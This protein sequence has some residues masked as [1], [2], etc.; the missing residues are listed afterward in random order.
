MDIVKLSFGQILACCIF[1]SGTV[2]ALE[3]K[4][5]V[6]SGGD[7]EQLRYD[8]E[9]CKEDAEGMVYFS[10]RDAVF[11]V[12]YK[13]L[14]SIRG[15]SAESRSNLP[16]RRDQAEQ[17][18]CPGNPLWGKGFLI[19]YRYQ[20]TREDKAVEAK[21]VVSLHIIASSREGFGLQRVNESGFERIRKSYGDC[22]RSI[23]GLI[24]CRK[25]TT[26]KSLAGDMEISG[27][28]TS[29]KHYGTPLGEKLT[30]LCTGPSV[31]PSRGRACRVDYKL[32]ENINVSYEFYRQDVPMSSF[33]E[34]D[35]ALRGY[36]E[37]ARV[38]NYI[39]AK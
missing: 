4:G 15:M 37:A 14:V 25:P 32:E 35:R 38:K 1:F 27:Y 19:L 22:D 7:N 17:E 16:K 5:A 18:G 39:W 33:L 21:N 31:S 34:F 13:D 9:K 8:P 23:V 10:V 3:D 11:K 36:I 26:E 20:D 12:S 28:Q 29:L 24:S 6:R 30:V 2:A